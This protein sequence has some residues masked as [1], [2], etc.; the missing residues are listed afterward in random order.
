MGLFTF[1]YN[2]MTGFYDPSFE[3]SFNGAVSSGSS[4]ANGLM[5]FCFSASAGGTQ[6]LF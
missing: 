1:I 2:S 4:V 5:V 3:F 6:V